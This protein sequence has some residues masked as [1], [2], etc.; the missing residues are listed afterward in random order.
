LSIDVCMCLVNLMSCVMFAGAGLKFSSRQT[1]ALCLMCSL[2]HVHV[3]FVSHAL[4]SLFEPVAAKAA[5]C[6]LVLLIL[7][8]PE[9]GLGLR[10]CLSSPQGRQTHLFPSPSLCHPLPPLE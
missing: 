3:L 10:T 5:F 9:G 6:T 4:C 1:C 7:S 2:F 8:R